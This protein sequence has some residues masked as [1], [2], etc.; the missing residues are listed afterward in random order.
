MSEH[1][2]RTRWNRGESEFTYE[3]YSRDHTWIF[4]G[5]SEVPASAAPGFKGNAEFVDPEEAFVASVSSCHMLTFLALA[6]RKR[7]VVESYEDAATGALE[8][9]ADGKLAMTRI[10]LDPRVSFGGSRLPSD[11]ELARLHHQAHQHCFIAN[12]VLTS[13]TLKQD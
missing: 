5:G 1:H 10:V 6:A 7:F 8:K 2:A 11:E 13:V 4:E 3:A 9:N 12:S